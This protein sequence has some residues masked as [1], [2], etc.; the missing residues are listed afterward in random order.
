MAEVKLTDQNFN[1]EVIKSDR[2]VL[3][4][5]W[6]E[7]CGPCRV[8]LPVIEELVKECEGEKVKIGKFNIDEN[9]EIIAKYNIMS[10]P[11]F[12]FF[13]NGEVV[14]QLIG[15]QPKDK[16]KKIIEQNL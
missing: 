12:I 7:W 6:A 4:D 11:T 2:L 8:M 5:F 16:L 14:K 1:E 10:I 15:S 13:K 3:V 9:Q